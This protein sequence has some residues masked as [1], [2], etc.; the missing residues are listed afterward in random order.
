MRII[1]IA[2]ALTFCVISA[3]AMPRMIFPT[4]KTFSPEYVPLAREIALARGIALSCNETNNVNLNEDYFD[5]RE[6]AV[7][8]HE[9]KAFYT[10]IKNHSYRIAVRINSFDQVKRCNKEIAIL[11]ARFAYAKSAPICF[12]DGAAAFACPDSKTKSPEGT[13][14]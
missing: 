9:R 12:D 4:I 11:L 3:D 8:T 6:E 2:L 13:N 14:T 5:K 10:Y 1:T 7:P